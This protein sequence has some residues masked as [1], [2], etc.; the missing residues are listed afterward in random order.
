MCEGSLCWKPRAPR[1]RLDEVWWAVD[2]ALRMAARPSWSAFCTLVSPANPGEPR[3]GVS[4]VPA[5][6]TRGSPRVGDI[7]AALRRF[8]RPSW[9]A[10]TSGKLLSRSIGGGA[11][12]DCDRPRVRTGT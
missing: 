11:S 2:L 8:D 4:G 9:A 6:S 5:L 10:R 7:V 3:S 12:Y 1:S